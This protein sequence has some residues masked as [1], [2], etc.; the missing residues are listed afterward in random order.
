MI[1]VAKEM[2][3]G[4]RFE[5][6]DMRNFNLNKK[7]HVITCAFDAI[8]YI[9]T[10]EDMKNTMNSI[11]NHLEDSGLFIF[12][13]NTPSLYEDKHFGV[14]NR[15]FDDVHFKQILEY[16]RTTQIGTTIFDFGNK[17]LE[18]HIQRAYSVETMDK[19]LLHAG[20]EIIGRYRNFKLAP[21][22]DRTYKVFYVVKKK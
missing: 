4:I 13:M 11:Y 3:T 22:E 5:V 6:G 20:F 9:I 10:H 17:E 12:D 2:T 21:I 18:T 16:D 19:Y 8:N 7:F 15:V 14:I 1:K